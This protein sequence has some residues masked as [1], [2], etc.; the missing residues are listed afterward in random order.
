MR[1]G[2]VLLSKHGLVLESAEALDETA[3]RRRS[4]SEFLCKYRYERPRPGIREAS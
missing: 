4:C 3:P 2:S 1:G